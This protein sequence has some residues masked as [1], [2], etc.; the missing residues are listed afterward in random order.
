L[1]L[2][3]VCLAAFQ[4]FKNFL[5]SAQNLHAFSTCIDQLAWESNGVSVAFL[6]L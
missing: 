4:I 6:Q 2:T 3:I 1:W 5:S